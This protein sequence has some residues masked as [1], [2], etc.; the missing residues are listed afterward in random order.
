MPRRR[1]A[2]RGGSAGHSQSG[3]GAAASRQAAKLEA[4]EPYNW[5]NVG[6]CLA[7]AGQGGKA[8]AAYEQAVRLDAKYLE[9]WKALGECYEKA[10]RKEDA[11]AAIE[12]AW[13]PRPDLFKK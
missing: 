5:D 10:G 8:I 6:Q 13:T 12:K 3:N 2:W 7:G 9:A 1:P 11:R 4:Q